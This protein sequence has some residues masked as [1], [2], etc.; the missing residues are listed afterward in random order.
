M[1]LGGETLFITQRGYLVTFHR[2]QNKR[3]YIYI[4]LSYHQESTDLY[5]FISRWIDFQNV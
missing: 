2:I 4:Y 3:I 5:I 1:I